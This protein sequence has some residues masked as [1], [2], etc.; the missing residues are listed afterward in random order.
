MDIT[1]LPES[2]A[3]VLCVLDC[4]LGMTCREISKETNLPIRTTRYALTILEKKGAIEKKFNFKDGR[5]VIYR[6]RCCI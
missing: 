5:S 1:E 2:A 6:L 4:G 3:T